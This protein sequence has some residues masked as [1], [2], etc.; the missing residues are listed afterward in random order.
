MNRSKPPQLMDNLLKRFGIFILIYIGLLLVSQI[1]VVQ[2][3]HL[4][5][6]CQVGDRVFNVVNPNLFANF[7][8]G[9]PPNEQNWN[10]TFALYNRD[11]HKGRGNLNSK[12]YRSKVNPNRYVYR[13]TY[14]LIL[15]PT[16]F[17]LALFLA[18][19]GLNWKRGILYFFICLLIIYVFL[20]FHYSHV[21]ENLIINEGKTG[22][23][24]WHKFI[25]I[26]G[27]KGLTEPIYIIAILS[28]AILTFK[29]D[30]LSKLT[31]KN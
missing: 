14:E 10:T 11:V 26:F 28:W 29:A 21:I 15:L 31:A 2:D 1:K 27:F 9:A 24:F 8:P 12:A 30:M 16:F 17:L 19:P 6:Y 23:S 3:A 13:D 20:T 4:N 7:I 25:S 18:T 5:Y 22:D